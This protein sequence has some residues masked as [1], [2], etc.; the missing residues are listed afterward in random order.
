MENHRWS[1]L[2]RNCSHP[3]QE[4][5]Y[6]FTDLYWLCLLEME[7]KSTEANLEVIHTSSWQTVA[8]L[9]VTN[10]DELESLAL[11]AVTTI[12][13]Q[14]NSIWHEAKSS[15]VGRERYN[16][17]QTATAPR[18]AHLHRA[19]GSIKTNTEETPTLTEHNLLFQPEWRNPHCSAVEPTPKARSSLVELDHRIIESYNLEKMSKIIES[20]H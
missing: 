6:L 1:W 17:Y 2:V 18:F 15:T 12:I 9:L 8:M 11:N 10:T 19:E 13:F 14:T 16:S 7:N 3:L 5:F 20:I 4:I